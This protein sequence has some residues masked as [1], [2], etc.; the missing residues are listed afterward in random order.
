MAIEKSRRENKRTATAN[1]KERKLF[2]YE[3]N[4]KGY[5][6]LGR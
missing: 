5:V 1:K 6:D 3:P 2:D 4:D